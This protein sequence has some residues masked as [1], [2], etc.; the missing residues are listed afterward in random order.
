[1]T[2]L[3]IETE[4]RLVQRKKVFVGITVIPFSIV[5]EVKLEQ[6]LNVEV[7]HAV[8]DFGILMEVSEVH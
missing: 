4:V 8:I 5:T 7:F 1:M 3:G 2:L 6:S